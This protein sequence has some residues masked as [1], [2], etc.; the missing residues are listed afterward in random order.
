MRVKIRNSKWDQR[1]IYQYRMNEFEEFI[2]DEIAVKWLKPSQL[3]ITTG[4]PKFPFR[5]I[6]RKY[7]VSIDSSD[8]EY[9]VP[10]A[11]PAA[12]VVHK[13]MGSRG[14]EYTVTL[15]ASPRCTCPG[16]VY[17]HACKHVSQF[18]AA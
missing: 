14:K 15:G 4:D 16:F 2:G 3:A 13:V 9:H 18:T 1:H 12:E 7:I 11:A 6:E 5:V 8:Y 10:V 17:R